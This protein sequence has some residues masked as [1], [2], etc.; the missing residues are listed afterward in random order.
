[1]SACNLIKKKGQ[2]CLTLG[3]RRKPLNLWPRI[4]QKKKNLS[5]KRL[6][7][8]SKRM[9]K[10]SEKGW[11]DSY[12]F[13]KNEIRS[14]KENQEGIKIHIKIGSTD[15]NESGRNQ[16]SLRV[17]ALKLEFPFAFSID[18][19]TNLIDWILKK[20]KFWKIWKNFLQKHLK[21]SFCDMRCMFMISNVFQNQ[22]FLRKIQ[23]LANFM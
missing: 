16:A 1:M 22:T 23:T 2:K 12:L 21:N 3:F 5:E 20:Q 11:T 8:E 17:L 7:D 4:R 15:R 6:R 9:T 13:I 10:N 19:K 18:R 14:V